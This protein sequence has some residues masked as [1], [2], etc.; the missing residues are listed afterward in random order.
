MASTDHDRRMSEEEGLK[1]PRG[2]AGG[3]AVTAMKI[4]MG[5]IDDPV[6]Q[7]SDVLAG[8]KAKLFKEMIDCLANS[9]AVFQSQQRHDPDLTIEEKAKIATDV[10]HANKSM[11]LSRFGQFVKDEHLYYFNDPTREQDYEIMFHLKRLRRYHNNLQRQIDV[12]NRRYQALKSLIDKGEYFSETEMMRR[13]PLLYEHLIGQY[14]TEEQRKGRDNIDTQNIS[15]LNIVLESVDRERTRTLQKEQ[16][17]AEDEVKEEN[18]S[19]NDYEEELEL[20]DKAKIS[21][22]QS[23]DIHWGEMFGKPSNFHKKAQSDRNVIDYTVCQISSREQQIL[24][25]EFL[26]NMYNSF[27][28]GKDK[29]FDY[30]TVDENESYDN[31]ELRTQD[32]E[33]KYFDSE[34]PEIVEKDTDKMERDASSGE[35]ELD[36]YMKSLKEEPMPNRLANAIKK[37]TIQ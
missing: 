28:N 30:S 21:S 24:R 33:E 35:D 10:F 32:E 18:D 1:L 36:K 29:D 16:Q 14:L 8:K 15:F 22:K 11:F 20:E 23:D 3:S 5:P 9:D 34:S 26:T 25:D 37:Q 27:L 19:D 7:N 12:K 17:D 13:N 6:S 31:T 4:N 2:K